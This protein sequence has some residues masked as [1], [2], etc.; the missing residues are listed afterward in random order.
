MTE[1][2]QKHGWGLRT[3]FLRMR[4]ELL[5]LHQG[6]A[7]ETGAV[8]AVRSEA[9]QPL[10]QGLDMAIRHLGCDETVFLVGPAGV[11]ALSGTRP[12][13]PR[14]KGAELRRRC[15]S[16]PERGAAWVARVLE[17]AVS[18]QDKSVSRC[19]RLP[20][21]LALEPAGDGLDSERSA[22]ANSVPAPVVV[23][24]ARVATNPEPLP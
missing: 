12:G 10:G 1:A 19:R 20:Q 15:G 23:S 8:G 7:G 14:E 17:N 9:K 11:W 18:S 2:G 5:A 16:R 22:R 13:W 3:S 21:I 4:L 24:P 6:Q